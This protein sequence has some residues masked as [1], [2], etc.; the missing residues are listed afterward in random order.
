MVATKGLP[1]R[2]TPSSAGRRRPGYVTSRPLMRIAESTALVVRPAGV[3]PRWSNTEKTS[4]A[5]CI[6][7]ALA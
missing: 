5:A 2:L 3:G 6:P 4:W 1:V 7:S